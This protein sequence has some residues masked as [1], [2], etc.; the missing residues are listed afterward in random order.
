MV[1]NM[2]F[3]YIKPLAARAYL[4]CL[5]VAYELGVNAKNCPLGMDP[6][7]TSCNSADE[8]TSCRQGYFPNP[9]PSFQQCFACAEGCML[10]SSAIS[11]SKCHS[12]GFYMEQGYCWPCKSGCAK[13]AEE[14]TCQECEDQYFA[15]KGNCTLLK[16]QVYIAI[17][18]LGALII[19]IIACCYALIKVKSKSEVNETFYSHFQNKS[20]AC[21]TVSINILDEDAKKD[22]TKI[23]DVETIGRV[24]KGEST[25]KL[26]F[27]ENKNNQNIMEEE[28][29][30]NK[31]N[32]DF[33]K[34]FLTG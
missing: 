7:C 12:D 15:V 21:K 29:T 27:I 1:R 23:S 14:D 22:T 34:S 2:A 28:A 8:C 31:K 4:I 19:L 20:L 16:V 3:L 26:S 13:C 5:L 33:T 10:C 11:C 9:N 30:T 17:V 25:L 32:L 18:C 24:Q 6:L